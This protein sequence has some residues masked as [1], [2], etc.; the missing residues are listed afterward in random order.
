MIKHLPEG[1]V[2]FEDCGFARHPETPLIGD[3]IV[4]DCRVDQNAATPVLHWTVDGAAQA[5]RAGIRSGEHT[6]RFSLGRFERPATLSY[7]IQAGGE[8]SPPHLPLRR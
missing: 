5:Q 8:S 3:E 2:P 4:I 7:R 6:Y 1:L